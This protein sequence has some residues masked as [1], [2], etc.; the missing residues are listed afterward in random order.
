MKAVKLY[1]LTAIILFILWLVVSAGSLVL[2]EMNRRMLST[3]IA[4]SQNVMVWPM[5]ESCARQ[6]EQNGKFYFF[7]ERK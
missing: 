5:D 6:F 2:L 3:V 7:V 4:V 1:K